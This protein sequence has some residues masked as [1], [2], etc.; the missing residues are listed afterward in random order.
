MLVKLIA[1]KLSYKS[2]SI[3]IYRVSCYAIKDRNPADIAK[4]ELLWN[5]IVS[6]QSIKMIFYKYIALHSK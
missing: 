5:T 4:S 6:L 1:W 3:Q 2:F